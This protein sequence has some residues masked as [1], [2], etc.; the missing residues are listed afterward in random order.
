MKTFNRISLS[1][2]VFVC[3]AFF[4][5]AIFAAPTFGSN[6]Y[7]YYALAFA[8]LAAAAATLIVTE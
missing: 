5:A 6:H 4:T 7:Y 8:A 1:F 3:G 2:S